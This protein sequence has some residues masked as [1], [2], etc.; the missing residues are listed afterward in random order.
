M[1]LARSL[2]PATLPHR[3]RTK[4]VIAV[5]AIVA[6]L[7]LAG[8]WQFVTLSGH[9]YF[10]PVFAVDGLRIYVVERTTQGFV[11]GLGIEHFTSPAHAWIV[12]DRIRLLRVDSGGAVVEELARWPST[13]LVGR[14]LENYRGRMFGTLSATLDLGAN[15]DL[16][17]RLDLPVQR[18]PGPEHHRVAGTWSP[19]Q[20]AAGA[21][22]SAWQR[23]DH[24]VGGASQPLL[25]GNRE[26][27]ALRAIE[28][29]PTGVAILDH[30][31]GATTVVLKSARYADRY[32][33]GLS[34]TDLL[35]YSQRPQR[36]RL[37]QIETVTRERLAEYR[38][39][40]MSDIEARLETQ[41]DL[42]D[43]GLVPRGRRISARLIDRPAATHFAIDPM[44]FTVGLFADIER[45][46]TQPAR[47][48][49][50]DP[51]KYIRHDHYRHSEPI[52]RY[53]DAGGREFSVPYH[54]RLYL[55]EI[56]DG[57]R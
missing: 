49:G 3:R 51:G 10:A 34:A 56:D 7:L 24:S 9:G 55:V 25:H 54:G 50:K 15:G 11:W 14:V 17:Y 4:I 2:Q 46:I 12:S 20:A 5:L 23:A 21:T 52:N 35:E 43:R 27:F 48:V 44:E 13:P 36:D 53:L 26:V 30:D 18:I 32:P 33:N 47:R 31:T 57:G 39:R 22:P 29:Y 6:G 28:S 37:A 45:A 38:A 41:F 40:G 19:G 42:E 8:F 16:H 1:T